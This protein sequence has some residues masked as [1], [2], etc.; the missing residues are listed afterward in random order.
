MA[1]RIARGD[2]DISQ[3]EVYRAIVAI[4]QVPALRQAWSQLRSYAAE[5]NLGLVHLMVRQCCRKADWSDYD[6]LLSDAH[7]VLLR[8]ID[9]FDP[10]LNYAFST[11]A[12]NCIARQLLRTRKRGWRRAAMEK[13][14][15]LDPDRGATTEVPVNSLEWRIERLRHYLT[16]GALTSRE[17][18]VLR[19]RYPLRERPK[20]TLRELA[21]K[22]N[23]SRERTRQIEA[24]ALKKIRKQIELDERKSP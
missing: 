1:K 2:D 17:K 6:E 9:H 3:M 22:L 19:H 8:A 5:K 14:M 24:K 11:Y 23:I 21:V 16:N 15:V 18:F 13:V 7:L 10:S 4:A 20:T 12:C